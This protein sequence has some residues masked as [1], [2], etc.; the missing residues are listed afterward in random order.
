MKKDEIQNV[1][2]HNKN[3]ERTKWFIFLPS[4]HLKKRGY[5]L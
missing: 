3:S 1:F 5:E 4:Y 2:V